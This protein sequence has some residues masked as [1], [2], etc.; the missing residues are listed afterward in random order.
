[1]RLAH[2]FPGELIASPLSGS[3]PELPHVAKVRNWPVT[4]RLGPLAMTE[5]PIP[6]SQRAATTARAAVQPAS[7]FLCG[8]RPTRLPAFVRA[9]HRRALWNWGGCSP[10]TASIG[11]SLIFNPPPASSGADAL[12]RA[13][14][15]HRRASLIGVGLGHL[16]AHG[17]RSIWLS[18][19]F[20]SFS[21]RNSHFR[22]S[23]A[24]QGRRDSL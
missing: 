20:L 14:G 15:V 11:S 22:E 10:L 5:L 6:F 19:I 9:P 17:V 4:S 23:L 13:Y 18:A 24:P 16:P 3:I 12:Q 8:G 7:A 2:T 1:M 21:R